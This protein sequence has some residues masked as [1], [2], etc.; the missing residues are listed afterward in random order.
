MMGSCP[1][2]LVT[3]YPRCQADG[4]SVKVI[5]SSNP[6]TIGSHRIYG[7]IVPRDYCLGD[8]L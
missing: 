2:V 1:L 8:M 4:R 6:D 3:T 7:V 5:C